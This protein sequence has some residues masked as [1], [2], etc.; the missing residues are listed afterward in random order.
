MSKIVLIVVL[1]GNEIEDLF[2][3]D[4]CPLLFDNDGD[5]TDST[6]KATYMTKKILRLKIKYL[7]VA[8]SDGNGQ[9]G[10]YNIYFIDFIHFSS[11]NFD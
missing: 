3:R 1:A 8:M 11:G 9:L 2:C 7:I 10:C 4:F 5:L 6:T